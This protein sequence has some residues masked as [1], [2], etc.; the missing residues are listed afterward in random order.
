MDVY[1]VLVVNS[2]GSLVYAVYDA[3]T[4]TLED[5]LRMYPDT[6]FEIERWEVY[7]FKG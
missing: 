6:D 1:V 5:L 3:S 4:T 7:N 2:D